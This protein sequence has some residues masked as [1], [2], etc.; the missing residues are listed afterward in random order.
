MDTKGFIRYLKDKGQQ[1]KN[2]P[3]HVAAVENYLYTHFGKSL[4][5]ANKND[6][7]A[8]QVLTRNKAYPHAVISYYE[9]LNSP[10][11]KEIKE[12]IRTDIISKIPKTQPPK[13]ILWDDFRYLMEQKEKKGIS[14]KD[15]VLLNIL[16]S[17]MKLKQIR[18]LRM[19]DIDFEKKVITTSSTDQ[20]TYHVTPETW[21]ALENYIP[22]ESRGKRKK[23]FQKAMAPVT[24]QKMVR[25]SFPDAKITPNLLWLSCKEDLYEA[26]K[27]TR[28]QQ[29]DKKPSSRIEKITKK[30]IEN[31]YPKGHVYDFYKNVL[32]IIKNVK[33][34]VF[35]IDSFP[36]EE[37]LNLYLEKIPPNVSIKILLKKPEDNFLTIAQKFKMKPSIEFEVRKN[38][39]CHDRLLFIDNECWV[40]GQSIKDAGKKP[41]Y[42]VKIEAGDLFRKVFEDLWKESSIL[43]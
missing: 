20:K 32:E 17:R 22:T 11:A 38:N 14:D 31:V 10:N 35:L 16:W 3:S 18:H 5:E 29:L 43:V 19:S 9:Y 39:D 2:Y 36:N 12:T 37:V 24:V 7:R 25:E 15:C 33:N 34:E 41:T 21:E 6:I 4:E 40:I 8:C 27:Q 23:L 28:F 30:T 13:L 1:P 26:G 42:L